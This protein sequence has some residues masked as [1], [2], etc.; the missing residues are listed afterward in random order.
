M[1]SYNKE[2]IGKLIGRGA[3]SSAYKY[4]DDQVIKFSRL[5]SLFGLRLYD[6]LKHD[7]ELCVQYLG[8]YVVETTI[9]SQPCDSQYHH[10]YSSVRRDHQVAANAM[11]V[12]WIIALT[13]VIL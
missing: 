13:G 3:N 6:K 9:I 1:L 4:G 10:V 2:K 7:Y 8:D 5:S 12:V 11:T